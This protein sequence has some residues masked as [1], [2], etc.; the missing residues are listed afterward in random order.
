MLQL[1][2]KIK[3][4]SS[5]KAK[6]QILASNSDYPLLSDVFRLAYSNKIHFGIK[7]IPP[8]ETKEWNPAN[9]NEFYTLEYCLDFLE[10]T[11][12][13]RVITGNEAIEQLS[14]VLSGTTKESQEV[15]KRI[16]A[17]DL[18]IG[19][20]ISTA[21]KVWKGLIP[22]QPQMLCSPYSEKTIANIKFP[23]IAQLK[24]D[25]ARCFAEVRPSGVQL[26][27]RAG[28]E[29]KGLTHIVEALESIFEERK[30]Q[31]PEGFVIDG[32][33]LVNDNGLA[34]RQLSNGIAN[35]AL[36]NTI[37]ADEAKTMYLEAWDLI[38]IE[39]YSGMK[40]GTYDHRFETLVEFISGISC[41]VPIESHEVNTL[42][43]ARKIYQQYV[44][45]GLE[46]I[47][48]KNKKS[49]WENKRS[50]HQVKFK[51]EILIDMKIV[52]VY[53]HS[54]DPNKLGGITVES[55]C[56]T[57]RTNCGSG[58]TDTNQVKRDG[59]F[60]NIPL[61]YR[62]ELNRERLWA[63]KDDLI[64]QIVEIKCNGPIKADG[65]DTMSLFLPIVM[66]IRHDKSVANKFEEVFK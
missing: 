18:D 29:Y 45:K 46:G 50:K 38:P 63:I 13:K 28:N 20:S 6:E 26:L 2:Q 64:G 43:E 31:Y 23:A 24:A 7:K 39:C 25:G 44:D 36:K 52:D 54:K 40:S 60:Y 48:L 22:E 12:A 17:K 42:E 41:I 57:I 59:K 62:D 65:K 56:G 58:F 35:K 53:V 61:E 32:E 66:K 37:S 11:L 10:N 27:S 34:N 49:L 9:R 55:E 5:T 47:I 16:L 4:T 51:E 33:L 1:F 19:V 30:E 3:E 15:I 21:N 14:E 8:Y